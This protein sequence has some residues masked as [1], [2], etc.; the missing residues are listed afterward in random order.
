MRPSLRTRTTA[1]ARPTTIRS[2]TGREKM[3]L[4]EKISWT[5]KIRRPTGCKLCSRPTH[6]SW[7]ISTSHTAQLDSKLADAFAS[8]KK[9]HAKMHELKKQRGFFK[10]SIDGILIQMA[11]VECLD[12]GSC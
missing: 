5:R 2:P 8:M 9:G 6:W 10:G 12:G 1:T 3:E 4:T 7:A 11:A